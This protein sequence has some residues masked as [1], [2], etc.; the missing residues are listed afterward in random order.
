MKHSLTGMS[1]P[2][3]ASEAD[4][5]HFINFGLFSNKFY[6]L[7]D[8]TLM[9]APVSY[10]ASILTLFTLTLNRMTLTELT[11]SIVTS[12]IILFLVS[13]QSE[14]ELVSVCYT[15]PMSCLASS[16]E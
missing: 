12:F 14:S 7:C 6:N 2:P 4:L 10:K 1:A 13:S 16:T 3:P 9:D 11:T 8:I 15:L 5:L